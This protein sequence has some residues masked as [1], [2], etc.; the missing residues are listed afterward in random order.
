MMPGDEH[1]PLGLRQHPARHPQPPVGIDAA[2]S[3]GAAEG[4][5]AGVGRVSEH[6]VH[7]MVGRGHPGDLPTAADIAVA[8]QRE[9]QS[10]LA[11]PQPHPAHRPTHGEPVEDRRD[12]AGDRLV[13]VP[14]DLAVGL[15]PHQPD[16]QAAAQLAAGG[17]A[18]DAAVE[19]GAQDVQFGL[20]CGPHRYA[21]HVTKGACGVGIWCDDVGIIVTLVQR[22]L[23]IHLFRLERR[24][25]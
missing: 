20:L 5:G 9:L 23:S 19:A 8:L 13:G 22:L 18:A 6:A 21:D 3:A 4:V 16:R 10:L 17:L 12:H 7:R 15:A 25:L 24:R 11:Q 2:L 14:A 1:L